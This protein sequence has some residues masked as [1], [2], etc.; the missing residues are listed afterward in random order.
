M[1]AQRGGAQSREANS[2]ID[3]IASSLLVLTNEAVPSNPSAS[4]ACFVDYDVCDS[5]GSFVILLR[6]SFSSSS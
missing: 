2:D 6:P 5:V 4:S 1:D 3:L